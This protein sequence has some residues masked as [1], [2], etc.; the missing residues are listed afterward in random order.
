[1][2]FSGENVLIRLKQGGKRLEIAALAEIDFL[3]SSLL[4]FAGVDK[5]A[6]LAAA[7]LTP[8]NGQAAGYKLAR[9]VATPTG[10]SDTIATGLATVVSVV[11]A[12]EDEP[13]LTHMFSQGDIGDQAGSPAAGSFILTSSKPTTSTDVT[14]IAATT[15]FSPVNWVAIGT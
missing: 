5:R 9:G 6:E 11:L 2:A 7:V 1:M 12:L 3:A 8:V 13:T 4:K 10:G 14:P 15:P